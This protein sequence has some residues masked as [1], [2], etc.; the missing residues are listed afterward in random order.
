MDVKKPSHT[1]PEHESMNT[2]SSICGSSQSLPQEL[3]PAAKQHEP[4]P[5]EQG[6]PSSKAPF[7]RRGAVR[8]V[9]GR[10]AQGPSGRGGTQ[11]VGASHSEQPQ[12]GVAELGS[13]HQQGQS[14]E[15]QFDHLVHR[16]D[17]HRGDRERDDSGLGAEGSAPGAHSGNAHG[18]GHRRIREGTRP[19]ST[20]TSTGTTRAT[21]M[22]FE[23]RLR[24]K[25]DATTG[26][27]AWRSGCARPRGGRGDRGA[28]QD[29]GFQEEGS[30][31][32]GG[33]RVCYGGQRVSGEFLGN[34]R[35]RGQGYDGHPAEL[36]ECHAESPGEGVRPRGGTRET[37]QEGQQQGDGTE[38]KLGDHVRG[39][40]EDHGQDV[41]P[42]ESERRGLPSYE[43]QGTQ[44][45]A[46]R[47]SQLEHQSWEL[48]PSL[49]QGLVG[50]GRLVLLEVGREPNSYL[51]T[52][53]QDLVGHA[54]AA[55]RLSVWNGAD[56]S[57]QEGVKFV[58]QQIV[59]KQPGVV[60]LA[61]SDTPFS[62]LQHANRRSDAQKEEL[63][64][65]RAHA[66][67]CFEGAAIVYRYCQQQG[68]HCV[69]SM[70]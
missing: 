46:G 58:L 25:V 31:Q 21:E 32:R 69:W 52:A 4:Q 41:R 26:C 10:G 54:E 20:R 44:L 61:P 50:H 51:T 14:Q 27:A 22:G 18:Q 64:L 67:K 8:E 63:Q 1:D 59:H 30:Q 53:V 7:P 56:L 62:P 39:L 35:D 60:W 45:S 3:H 48:V 43:A 70:S 23:D 65:K 55:K 17:G 49:F 68:I 34:T 24:G 36:D 2:N 5:D 9:D 28:H 15:G 42:R 66:Q 6:G 33:Q 37:P 12:D 16:G 29:P 19:W 57:S 47:A 40:P 11:A 13:S 38:G